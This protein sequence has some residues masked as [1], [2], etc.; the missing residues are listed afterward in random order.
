MKITK[1]KLNKII[2]EEVEKVT[3]QQAKKQMH[4]MRQGKESAVAAGIKEQ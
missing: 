2:A 4:S 3:T 1:S